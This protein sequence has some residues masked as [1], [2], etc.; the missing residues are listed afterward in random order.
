[1]ANR[2]E[3]AIALLAGNG[4]VLA[5]AG[6]ALMDGIV[7]QHDEQLAFYPAAI[8]IGSMFGV[9]HA[10][11][12]LGEPEDQPRQLFSHEGGAKLGVFLGPT[13]GALLVV[14]HYFFPQVIGP[15]IPH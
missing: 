8:L 9:W 6:K 2:K 11:D 15:I 7:V 4:A 5:I 3:R 13:V 1:M 14:I 12:M 10:Y